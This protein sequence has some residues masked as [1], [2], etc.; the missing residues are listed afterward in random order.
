MQLCAHIFTSTIRSEFIY[1]S[2][3]W[4]LSDVLQELYGFLRNFAF[5]SQELQGNPPCSFMY[6][7][8]EILV[9]IHAI[10]HGLY[11]RVNSIP[12]PVFLVDNR[13]TFLFLFDSI[14]F[15]LC[16]VPML[17]HPFLGAWIKDRRS[18]GFGY[19]TGFAKDL[20]WYLYR[21]GIR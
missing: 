12:H 4:K 1:A 18:F 6:E 10:R 8:H 19:I 20:L 7:Y 14:V 9:T 21:L 17:F 15:N 13:Y 16:F 2:T 11:I 5:L 3:T